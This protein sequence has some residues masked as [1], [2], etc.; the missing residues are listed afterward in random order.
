MTTRG[1]SP[2]TRLPRIKAYRLYGI[3]LCPQV[4]LREYVRITSNSACIIATLPLTMPLAHFR[5][6]RTHIIPLQVVIVLLFAA[7]YYPLVPMGI[8]EW[9][10]PLNET[11]SQFE[12][13]V[14]FSTGNVI[15][16]QVW[17]LPVCG[18]SADRRKEGLN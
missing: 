9:P 12:V 7:I 10:S 5:I 18:G 16:F 14:W 3:A 17:I 11:M 15:S 2:F 4:H 8:D 1:H 13:A 6:H